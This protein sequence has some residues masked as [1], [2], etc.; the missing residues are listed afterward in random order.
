[1]VITFN[2]ISIL[3]LYLRIF[4]DQTFRRVCYLGI[5]FIA[6]TGIAYVLATIFQCTPM[7]AFWNRTIRDKHCVNSGAFWISYSVLNI[8]TDL[9]ILALP[10]RQIVSLHL[11][12]SDRL[13]L[14][15]V[16]L[17]GAFV[18]VTTIVRMTTL[19][20]S[21]KDADPTCASPDLMRDA[22]GPI[23]ATIWSV[24][25][26]N[27]G[28]ICACLPMLRGLLWG[29]FPRFFSDSDRS[30]RSRSGGS[31]YRLDSRSAQ[32]TSSNMNQWA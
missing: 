1:M 8:A 29:L 21:A 7:S 10:I 6:T 22:G 20:S 5:A 13:A 27:T 16:F 14:L 15:G 4:I 23:P 19:A 11:P 18:C 28:T 31:S 26:A 30:P 17:L 9:F 25:E 3:Y 2:K 12:R 24:V 32:R